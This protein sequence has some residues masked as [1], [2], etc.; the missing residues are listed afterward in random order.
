M[1]RWFATCSQVTKGTIKKAIQAGATSVK[2]LQEST[3]S[4]CGQ[5][6]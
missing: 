5:A 4:W 3:Q 1:T 6:M 2:A